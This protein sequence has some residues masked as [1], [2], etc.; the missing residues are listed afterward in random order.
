MG[1]NCL[2]ES[3]GGRIFA[4]RSCRCLETIPSRHPCLSKWKECNWL[5]MVLWHL[6]NVNARRIVQNKTRNFSLPLGPWLTRLSGWKWPTQLKY[7]RSLG[8]FS[9]KQTS[10]FLCQVPPPS[11]LTPNVAHHIRTTGDSVGLKLRSTP[12]SVIQTHTNPQILRNGSIRFHMS[13]TIKINLFRKTILKGLNKPWSYIWILFL[14][15]V[16]C[17]FSNKKWFPPFL[18]AFLEEI[19]Q[20]HLTKSGK[21]TTRHIIVAASSS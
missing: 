21:S 2:S 16:T 17:T 19:L 3:D 10:H 12:P 4:P 18:P 1:E 7:K 15:I 13:G 9:E 14:P 20:N 5:Q 6:Q 8:W 11:W